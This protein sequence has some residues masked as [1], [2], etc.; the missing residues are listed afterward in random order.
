MY[1]PIAYQM[2]NYGCSE[3]LQGMAWC[4]SILSDY[5]CNWTWAD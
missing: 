2:M 5:I 3:H 1:V 4:P